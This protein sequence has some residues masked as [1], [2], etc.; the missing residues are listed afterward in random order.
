MSMQVESA[1]CLHKFVNFAK[2]H[3]NNGDAIARF[4][5]NDPDS[6]TIVA[7]DRDH[8]RGFLNWKWHGA[9]NAAANNQI[10][11]Q[12]ILNVL[13]CLGWNPGSHNIDEGHVMTQAEI[14]DA[15]NTLLQGPENKARR[16]A[17]LDALKVGDYGC[18]KPLSSRRINATIAQVKELVGDRMSEPESVLQALRPD[19]GLGDGVA[20]EDANR[21]D[22][23]DVGESDDNYD[24]AT[25][26]KEPTESERRKAGEVL[27][28][29]LDEM[30]NICLAVENHND[31]ERIDG[32]NE[33]YKK[34]LGK[35]NE[36][37]E[38]AKWFRSKARLGTE[39]DIESKS[40]DH[41]LFGQ[42]WL[43]AV[44]GRNHDQYRTETWA[45]IKMFFKEYRERYLASFMREFSVE[46]N[47]FKTDKLSDDTINNYVKTLTLLRHIANVLKAEDGI[48]Y[49]KTFCEQMNDHERMLEAPVVLTSVLSRLKNS[50][51]PQRR[52][53]AWRAM[54]VM[55]NLVYRTKV[56]YIPNF[57]VQSDDSVDE[58]AT[59]SKEERIKELCTRSVVKIGKVG[60]DSRSEFDLYKQG[61][62][63]MPG[64]T[65]KKVW[66]KDTGTYKDK[67]FPH[68]IR[69]E[70]VDCKILECSEISAEHVFG[71][72]PE[73]L[74]I[75]VPERRGYNTTV[76]KHGVLLQLS[77]RQVEAL[78]AYA[79]YEGQYSFVET[80][81]RVLNIKSKNGSKGTYSQIESFTDEKSIAADCSKVLLNF[82]LRESSLNL[83]DD[84]DAKE[85]NTVFSYQGKGGKTIVLGI[86]TKVD[87]LDS[88][89][90]KSTIEY[91][92]TI[93]NKE[94]RLNEK[95]VAE[96]HL[97]DFVDARNRSIRRK[98]ELD[99]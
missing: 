7:T 92:L 39:D 40:S 27:G 31:D 70:G 19:V 15:V 47:T 18:G 36:V 4:A 32:N 17:L 67:E 14:K 37:L 62:S 87:K 33:D 8:I 29:F 99:A 45:G 42:S 56:E 53:L 38:F 77:R 96:L 63:L 48:D 66:D 94:Y 80:Q 24:L 10:R 93:G 79:R 73:F 85:R 98:Q 74:R 13:K 20:H 16:T 90:D 86:N 12:F 43:E 61:E 72:G 82:G 84:P 97:E 88:I 22:M 52:E 83:S 51:D 59:L 49:M 35:M 2:L 21:I 28:N 5:E 46:L 57:N 71:E 30:R 41:T 64:V 9:A 69:Y 11:Q 76:A 44:G 68:T 34:A 91:T 89:L 23:S 55:A 75:E 3:E 95:V 60:I 54:N 81:Q 1:N 25:P 65:T 50:G 78:K 6:R 26:L 58:T